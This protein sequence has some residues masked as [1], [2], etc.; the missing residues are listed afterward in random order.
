[1]YE[2]LPYTH[3]KANELGVVVK[4]SKIP[5]YKIDVYDK[6]GTFIFSGGASGYK[7]YPHYIK[8][9]GINYANE[10]RRLY[11]IRHEKDIKVVGGRGSIINHLLW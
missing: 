9:K 7:D 11:Q 8:E 4:P 2:I 10:R 1:M 3:Q 5:K 6:K